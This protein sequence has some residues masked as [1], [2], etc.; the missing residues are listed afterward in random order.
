MDDLVACVESSTSEALEKSNK[1]IEFQA[2]VRTNMADLLETYVCSDPNFNMTEPDEEHGSV[3]VMLDG[4]TIK[5][6]MIA[7]FVNEKECE[8]MEKA[9]DFKLRAAGISG[10]GK[11]ALAGIEIPWDKRNN[12]IA[13]VGRRVIDYAKSQ[14]LDVSD[15]GQENILSFQSVVPGKDEEIGRDLPSC[16]G[17]C[18]DPTKVQP[19]NRIATMVMHC[20]VPTQGGAANFRNAGLHLIPKVGSAIFYSY[21]DV[22]TENMDTGFSIRSACPVVEGESKIVTQ[23]LR[24]GVDKEHSWDSFKI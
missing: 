7:D 6:I 17:E 21:V 24:Y 13:T 10:E 18:A 23:W 9:A 4:K 15:E 22:E 19:G 11:V 5:V 2:G 12:V 20:K 3:K 8:A 14:N 1:E 16:D